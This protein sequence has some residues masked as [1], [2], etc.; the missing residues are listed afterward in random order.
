MNHWMKRIDI[1]YKEICKNISLPDDNNDI[2][3]E[4]N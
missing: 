3:I 1:A 4:P 2:G